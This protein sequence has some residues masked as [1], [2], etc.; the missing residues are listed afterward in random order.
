MLKLMRADLSVLHLGNKAFETH[1]IICESP[2]EV[3]ALQETCRRCGWCQG[4]SI[5]ESS[6]TDFVLSLAVQ[7]R[8]MSN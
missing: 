5:V 2:A 6:F 7:L 4:S 8:D 3:M 1:H